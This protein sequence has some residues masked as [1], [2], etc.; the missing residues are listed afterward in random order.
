MNIK[1]MRARI[2]ELESELLRAQLK[3]ARLED[4]ETDYEPASITV[5]PVER[6]SFL[7]H[8]R[9]I[10]DKVASSQYLT[11]SRADALSEIR[12]QIINCPEPSHVLTNEK[13]VMRTKAAQAT[14]STIG[15]LMAKVASRSILMA[16]QESQLAVAA[17]LNEIMLQEADPVL[18]CSDW[19][20]ALKGWDANRILGATNSDLSA[21]VRL[22]KARIT[23]D[24][25]KIN[26]AVSEIL[27]GID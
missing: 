7:Q 26:E 3:L 25:G 13:Q 17:A 11:T 2:D 16:G 1:Q 9:S 10:E 22:R 5:K 8:C 21:L 15:Q 23:G 6:V 19:L 4:D 12:W 14:T 20:E 27:E 18:D 24:L